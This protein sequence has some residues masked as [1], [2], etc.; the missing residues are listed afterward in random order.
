M[1]ERDLLPFDIQNTELHTATG[2]ESNVYKMDVNDLH[3]NERQIALKENKKIELA[4]D[5][6]MQKLKSFYD[7]LKNDPYLGKF[8]IESH[9]VKAQKT[10][11]EPARAYIVQNFISGK[12]IDEVS[13]EEMYADANLKAE[14]IQFIDACVLLLEGSG[15]D[16][17]KVPDLYADRKVFLGNLLHNPRYTGNVIITPPNAGFVQ[18]VHFI[19]AGSLLGSTKEYGILKKMLYPIDLKLQIMQLKRWRSK[20]EK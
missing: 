20:L 1:S 16:P 8:V 12:R 14:L 18:R 3:G 15:N 7:Y 13:N 11:G 19:D 9:F 5:V 4:D 10:P 17:T 6:E 2:K